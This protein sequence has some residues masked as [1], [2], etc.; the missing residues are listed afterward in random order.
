MI[1]GLKEALITAEE[2]TQRLKGEV[3]ILKEDMDKLRASANG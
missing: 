2:E 3:L 1:R